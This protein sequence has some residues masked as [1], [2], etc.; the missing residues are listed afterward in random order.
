MNQFI[1]YK[2]FYEAM[3]NI[4]DEEQTKLFKMICN[5]CFK[6]EEPKEDGI[7]KALFIVMKENID[8]ANKRYLAN[9]ENGKKGGRPKTQPKPN[10]NPSESELKPEEN[11]NNNINNNNN[12][13][14][15][16]N[17]NNNINIK[18]NV[19]RKVYYENEKLN[20]IF[21]EFLDIRKKLKA[22]NSDRAINMLIKK[23]S[24]YEDDIK[25]KMIEQSIIKSW[26]DIYELKEKKQEVIY[27]E[28]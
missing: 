7:A 5:Y 27:E 23:L 25:Y 8:S 9:I 14:K 4:P 21:L 22:I 26:K 16:N 12:N 10:Q 18:E 1:F 6:G 19:K 13:N 2:S 20:N 24:N 17:I 11:H 15:N 28:L 3:N